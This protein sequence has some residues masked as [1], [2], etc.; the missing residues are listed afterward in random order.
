MLLASSI[1]GS[2][3]LASA[4]YAPAPSGVV[5]DAE[6]SCG[7][8]LNCPV[9]SGNVLNELVEGALTLGDA[10]RLILS[11][12]AGKTIVS[13]SLPSSTI[14]FRNTL[15]DKTRVLADVNA[16]GERTTVTLDPSQ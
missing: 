4:E 2:T 13:G 11:V 14:A 16:D 10:I 9:S 5:V 15:D 12:S 7:A 6:A 3:V 1:L 8:N